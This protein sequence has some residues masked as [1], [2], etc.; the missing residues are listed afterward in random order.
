MMYY[1]LYYSTWGKTFFF[2]PS[3]V[4]VTSSVVCFSFCAYINSS[5]CNYEIYDVQIYYITAKT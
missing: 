3:T 2:Q 4:T 5:W 1:A